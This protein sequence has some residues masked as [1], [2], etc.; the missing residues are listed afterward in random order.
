M[1]REFTHQGCPTHSAL[2][3]SHKRSPTESH[4]VGP[5][6]NRSYTTSIERE[7][8]HHGGPTQSGPTESHERGP[9][10]PLYRG[11]SIVREVLPNHMKEVLPTISMENGF[12][13]QGSPTEL[14]EEGPT[15][16]RSYPISM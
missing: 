9:T 13:R 6:Y 4:K 10:E 2:T 15:Y 11:G 1:E 3:E 7:F 5:T 8:L 16:N 12:F 14:F